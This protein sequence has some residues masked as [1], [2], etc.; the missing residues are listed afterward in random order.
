MTAIEAVKK[1]LINHS[2]I[3]IDESNIDYCDF[4][5]S[6][7]PYFVYSNVQKRGYFQSEA[8]FCSKNEVNRIIDAQMH[9]KDKWDV[10]IIF[11]VLLNKQTIVGI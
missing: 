9:E 11:D 5:N 8:K 1:F 10:V 4:N 3:P 6:N 7:E 2:N